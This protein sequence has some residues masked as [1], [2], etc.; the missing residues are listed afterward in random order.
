MESEKMSFE[1][2][3]EVIKKECEG[4]EN[5]CAGCEFVEVCKDLFNL[6]PREWKVKEYVVRVDAHEYL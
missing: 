6:F 2:G 1:E 4:R 3:L 5:R